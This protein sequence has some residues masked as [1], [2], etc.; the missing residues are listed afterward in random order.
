MRPQLTFGGDEAKANEIEKNSE[1][2]D[3]RLLRKDE[4]AQALRTAVKNL[5][6]IEE[7][8]KVNQK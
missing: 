1:N 6:A 8:E 4:K 2:F 3:L 5:V 7:M